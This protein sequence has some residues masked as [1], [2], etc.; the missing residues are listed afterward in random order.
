M[1]DTFD[2]VPADAYYTWA[3][4]WATMNRITSGIGDGLFAPDGTCT[5]AQIVSFLYRAQ[6]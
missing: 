4:A 6:V 2:D 5:R 3:V 1:L